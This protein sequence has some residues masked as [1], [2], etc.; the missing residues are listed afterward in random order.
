MAGDGGL[1]CDR[2]LSAADRIARPIILDRSEI[3]FRPT[4]DPAV[5][6]GSRGGS[7]GLLDS[8]DEIPWER[9]AIL[10]RFDQLVV[11]HEHRQ[12]KVSR[13]LRY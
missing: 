12:R 3:R 11:A 1:T 2:C 8:E 7:G 4:G 13:K 6:T 9:A 10:S 5:S